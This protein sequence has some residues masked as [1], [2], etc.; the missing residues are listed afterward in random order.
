[1]RNTVGPFVGDHRARPC[2]GQRWPTTQQASLSAGQKV[3]L[4]TGPDNQR[5]LQAKLKDIRQRVA[6]P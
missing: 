4:R 2:G 5:R 3:L 1:M 6:R